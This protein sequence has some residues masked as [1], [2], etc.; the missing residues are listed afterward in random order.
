MIKSTTLDFLKNLKK[1]NDREWFAKNKP[2]FEDA[3]KDMHL[4]L[5][6]L[7]HATSSFDKSVAGLA[8]KDCLMR[9]YR[10]VRFSKN[11]DPYKTNFGMMITKDGKKAAY[12]GYYMHI[13][14]AGSFIAGGLHMPEPDKLKNV[15]QEILY[16]VSEFK[17]I[18]AKPTFKKH[19]PKLWDEDKLVNAP[20][21]FPKDHPEV[22][23]LKYKSYIVSHKLTDKQVLDKN[24][25]K[26]C[27]LVFKE[28]KPF[29]D[30]LNRALD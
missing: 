16:N 14:P 25:V 18:L 19:F 27:V 1:N 15:R 8:P 26:Y 29:D 21:D 3:Q 23:L 2:K 10:D 13:A 9:I 5:E 7:I 17:K 12:A 4:F 24:F 22:E 11:K 30:F 20:K 28:L 6:E